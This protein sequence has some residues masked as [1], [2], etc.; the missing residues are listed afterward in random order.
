MIITVV[1]FFCE[2]YFIT[3]MVAPTLNLNTSFMIDV[4]IRLT[5]RAKMVSGESRLPLTLLLKHRSN[6]HTCQLAK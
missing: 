2:L 5:P 3:F 1:L 4:E 6:L